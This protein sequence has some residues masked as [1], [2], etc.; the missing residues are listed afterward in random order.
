MSFKIQLHIYTTSNAIHDASMI[1]FGSQNGHKIR[2]KSLPNW[3][4]GAWGKAFNE[5][6][7]LDLKNNNFSD[8]F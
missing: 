3:F 4:E 8:D 1:D 6:N 7:I 5:D 2:S